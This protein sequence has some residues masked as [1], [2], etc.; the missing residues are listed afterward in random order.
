MILEQINIHSLRSIQQSSFT[1]NSDLNVFHGPNG[2]GKTSILEAFYLLS[3]GYSFKTRETLPLVRHGNS[4]LTVFAKSSSNDSLSLRKS[5]S[6]VTQAK[7]NGEVCRSNSEL[8]RALPCLVVYQ[9]IFQVIDAGPSVRRSLLDWGVFHVKHEY[10]SLWL[11]YRQVLKQ[12]NALLRQK[13]SKEE[14]IPWNKLLAKLALELDVL[15]EG[16]MIEWNRAFQFFLPK[17]SNI[18]CSIDYYAGWNKRDYNL[19]DVLETQFSSDILRQYTQSGSHQADLRIK[20][21]NSSAKKELSRGQ[22][23]LILIAMKLAQA[24]L[25]GKPC[26]YLFDDLTSELDSFHVKQLME[27]LQGINGQKILTVLDLN[28]LP[29][30]NHNVNS[31]HS[32]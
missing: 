27:C 19:I 6:S 16:Y 2:S 21:P 23:K 10:H 4:Y 22:Q 14:F 26:L 18:T 8:S 20:T 28:S 13:A 30:V 29:T 12:R 9:D 7:I 31:F 17:L 11:D 32:L 24:S 1:L 5:L 25:L 15:R 3:T